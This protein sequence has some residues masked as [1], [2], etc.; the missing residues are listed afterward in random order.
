M[1]S[2]TGTYVAA[3]G[4]TFYGSWASGAMHGKCVFRP[5]PRAGSSPAGV[6]FLQ[7]YEGGRLVREQ[8]LR[9]AEKDVRK[10]QQKR[11]GKKKGGRASGQRGGARPPAA[12]SSWL[13][14]R[15]LCCACPPPSTPLLLLAP[16]QP[17]VRRARC[18][19][20]ERPSLER[21]CTGGTAGAQPLGL[22][23]AA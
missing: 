9:V 3:D 14:A 8:C 13:P 17:S 15:L 22:A 16:A 7:E 2:G 5:A 21:R 4:S 18:R 12:C 20:T 10:K 1:E 11:E 23:Q 6:V 19:R